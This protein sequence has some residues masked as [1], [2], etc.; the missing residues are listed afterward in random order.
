M[1]LRFTSDWKRIGKP[2]LGHSLSITKIAF[3]PDDSRIL[4]VGRDRSWHIHE[5]SDADDSVSSGLSTQSLVTD[6][7]H[8]AF[9]PLA[10]SS[11]AHARIIWDCC[12]LNN[13]TFATASRDKQVKIWQTESEPASWSCVATLAIGDAATALASTSQAQRYD[14]RC[15]S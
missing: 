6:S 7:F 3:S 13:R 8:I 10:S 14:A 11:K 12:W 2:L 5:R 9:L 15:L 1:H 4:T